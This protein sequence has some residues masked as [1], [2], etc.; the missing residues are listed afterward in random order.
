MEIRNNNANLNF[1]RLITTLPAE[2]LLKKADR[3]V[4]ATKATYLDINIPDGHNI[5]L[6][7]VLSK[8]VS[9][10]Q[11]LNKNDIVVDLV[12]DSKKLVSIK[13]FD[14]KGFPHKEWQVNPYPVT[15]SLKE[16]AGTN[17]VI[18]GN[19]NNGVI[20]GKSDFFDAIDSAE[21]DVEFLNELDRAAAPKIKIKRN[22]RPKDEVK[23]AQKVLKRKESL[24]L[25]IIPHMQRPFVNLKNM[26]SRKLKNTL[27][28]ERVKATVSS[29]KLPRKIKKAV[30]RLNADRQD[31]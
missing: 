2:K 14:S 21:F 16:V 30:K 23:H 8:S 15:G 18:T 7:S 31:S 17:A 9:D 29:E 5:P 3:A 19:A 4:K 13:T 10:R 28:P 24:C 1:G 27:Q 25:R 22:D 20:Y 6:W 26:L 12:K 11:I